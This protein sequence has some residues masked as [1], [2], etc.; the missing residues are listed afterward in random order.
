MERLPRAGDG[1]LIFGFDA[2]VLAGGRASRLGGHPKPQLTYRGATL[3]DH[4]LDA[5]DGARLTVVVGPGPGEPGGPDAPVEGRATPGFPRAGTRPSRLVLYTREVPLYAGPLAALG[6]GLAALECP[7]GQN[8]GQSSGQDAE[9][10]PDWVVV[11]AAD[12]PRAPD[13]VAAL[14]GRACDVAA[15]DP[16]RPGPSVGG[17]VGEDGEGRIQPLLAVY[18]REALGAAL[19]QLSTHGGLADRPMRHLIA[20]LDLLPLKLP[21]GVSDDV[22]TWDAARRWGIERPGTERVPGAAPRQEE[23]P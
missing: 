19:S 15:P 12:L 11:V 4:A 5:V 23:A 21:P 13:A 2:I 16:V 8:A 14:L 20:R 22:D 1:G 7:P 9:A 10:V 6:A 17:V 3:L 18:R